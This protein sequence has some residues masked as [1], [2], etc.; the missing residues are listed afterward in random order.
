MQIGNV[1][2]I[3]TS[4][5]VRLN[6]AFDYTKGSG[7]LAIVSKPENT[8]GWFVQCQSGLVTPTTTASTEVDI[9]PNVTTQNGRFTSSV[10]AAVVLFQNRQNWLLASTYQARINGYSQSPFVFT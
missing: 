3:S 2:V 1:Y 8:N 4:V 6:L 9:S 7:M 5:Q 10:P